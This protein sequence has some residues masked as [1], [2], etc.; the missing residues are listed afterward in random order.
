MP[1]LVVGQTFQCPVDGCEFTHTPEP[2]VVPEAS[3]LDAVFGM[4][5]GAFAR[6]AEHEWRQR[7]E[8]DLTRHLDKHTSVEWLTTVVGLRQRLGEPVLT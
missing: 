2:Y 8:A 6:R 5:P 4:P 7:I 1:T 3:A